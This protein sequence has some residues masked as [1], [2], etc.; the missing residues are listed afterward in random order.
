MGVIR[1]KL[2]NKYLTLPNEIIEDVRISSG[3]FR[4]FCYIS[5]KDDG[6]IVRNKDIQKRLNIKQAQTLANY[7]KEL[8]ESGWISR[9]RATDKNGNFLGGFDYHIMDK[10]YYGKSLITEN[11]QL[12]KNHNHSNTD[13]ISKTEKISNIEGYNFDSFWFD[14]DKKVG[15]KERVQKKFE[16][17][18]I[19]DRDLIKDYIP[20]YKAAQPEKKFR[21]NPETF[22]NQKA[23]N[24]ELINANGKTNGERNSDARKE[25]VWNQ[26]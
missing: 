24:D 2:K 10:P 11:P 22:L 5:S 16:K 12:R 14:Y 18:S 20:K 7:Y 25:R 26:N 8:C 19:K 21:K 15:L 3:A 1:N 17:L 6:W 9:V 23:W 4:V 13:L